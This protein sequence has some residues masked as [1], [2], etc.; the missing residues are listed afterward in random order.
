[1]YPQQKEVYG[2]RAEYRKQYRKN[3][4]EYV[5]RNAG[6]VEKYRMRCRKRVCE[7]VSPTSRDILLSICSQT[8]KVSITHVSSTS[9]DI[10]VTI[11]ESEA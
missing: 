3:K 9:R 8:G 7:A 2:T 1:M 4:P 10:L 5:Q 11:S 6:F